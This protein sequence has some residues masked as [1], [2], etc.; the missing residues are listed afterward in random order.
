[1]T[2]TYHCVRTTVL[3]CAGGASISGEFC[4]YSPFNDVAMP[5]STVGLVVT[6]AYFPEEM[7]LLEA[8][9]ILPLPGGPSSDAYEYSNPDRSMPFVTALGGVPARVTTLPDG[10]SRA[11][12][13]VIADYV[14][15][16]Q[17]SS[18]IQ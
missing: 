6:R 11:F 14:N 8:S 1:M 18:T 13:I 9:Y 2:K 4:I 15:D 7:A 5:D 17:K 10:S 3:R 12:Y 16:C